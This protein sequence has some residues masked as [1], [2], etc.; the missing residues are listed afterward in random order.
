M[1]RLFTLLFSIVA[2]PFLTTAQN[3]GVDVATPIQKLDVA[4]AIKLGSTTTG[5]AGS[6]RWTGTNFEVHDG[7]QWITFGTGT[8][9]DWAIL[10]SNMYSEPLGNVGIGT[11]TPATKLQVVG[12]ARVTALNVGGNYT[13]PTLDGG[14][15]FVLSTNGT[16]TVTWAD[17]GLTGDITSVVAGDGLI[18]GGTSGD[19]TVDVNPG[20]GIIL[21]G[22]AVVVQAS[23][24]EGNGLVANSNNFD[25]NVDNSTIEVNADQ[26]RV[27]AEGITANEIATGGVTTSEIL[28]G[29]IVTGDIATGGVNSTNIL[30]ATIVAADMAV[31]GNDQV[32]TTDGSGNPQWVNQNVMFL[33]QAGDGIILDAPNSELDINVDNST[34]EVNA[35][36]LRVKTSGITTSQI[37]DG[38][39]VTADIAT[40]GVTST[41]ILDGTIVP[42]DI[43]TGGVNSTNILDGTIAAED[44]G[45]GGAGQILATDATGTSV[46]WVNP[47]SAIPGLSD[48]DDDTRV[49]V[50]ANPDED[51]IRFDTQGSERMIIDETGNIGIGTTA[52]TYKLDIEGDLGINGRIYHNDDPNTSIQYT[53]DRLRVY[54]GNLSASWIDIQNAALEM[55][56]N[57]DGIQRD[58]RVESGSDAN[59]LIVVG[60][61][62]NVGVGTAAPATKFEV[63]GTARV[64]ELN[65]G[66]NYSLPT[67]DG[68]NT[69][70]MQTDGAGSVVWVDPTS[71]LT[72]VPTI[73]SD[74][75]LDT[76]IEVEQSADEDHIRMSTVGVERLTIDDAGQVGI[77]TNTPD[78]DLHIA[79]DN[80]GTLVLTR[81]DGSPV[82]SGSTLGELMFDSEAD[83]GPSPNDASAVIRGIASVTQGDSDKGG[84]MAFLTKTS[85]TDNTAAASERMRITSTG[86]VGI[87]TATPTEAVEV[88]GASP[89]ILISNTAE[90]NAGLMFHDSQASPTSQLAGMQFNSGS[91]NDLSFYNNSSGARMVI[92]NSGEVGIGTSNP[93]HP[94]EVAGNELVTGRSYIGT[95]DAY[96]YRDA[97]NRIAT[98]DMFYVQAS[99]PN[100]YLYSTNT[101]LGNSSGDNIYLRANRFNW[102]SGSGGEITTGGNLGLG[103]T[104]PEFKV[105]INHDGN[106]KAGNN[107][108]VSNLA[109]KIGHTTETGGYASG[110]GFGRSGV[111]S[112]VGGAI[113]FE[114]IGSQSNGHLHFATKNTSVSGGDIPIRMTLS[115][116]GRLGVGTTAPDHT[117]DV[118][119]NAEIS[120]LAG[121]G[122]RVVQAD[123][124]GT[125]I[126]SNN[127]PANDGS[128]IWNS[129]AGQG[130]NFRISGVGYVSTLY[131]YNSST[132]YWN[133]ASSASMRVEGN[134]YIGYGSNSDDDLIYFDRNGEYLMWYNS[135]NYFRVSDDFAADYSIRVGNVSGSDDDYLYFDATAEYIRWD[136]SPG[137]FDVSDDF[138]MQG[139]DLYYVDQAFIDDLYAYGTDTYIEVWDEF[140]MN[141]NSILDA[142]DVQVNTL[143]DPEDSWVYVPDNMYWNS[144]NAS[145]DV[146]MGY[147]GSYPAI[148][149]P[150]N[151]QGYLGTYY[152]RWRYSYTYYEYRQYEYNYSDRR[153]KENIR[154]LTNTGSLNKIMQLEGM[155]YDMIP[156]KLQNLGRMDASEL[157]EGANTEPA[158]LD[159]GPMK[160]NLG[161][162][163]QDLMLVIPEMVEYDEE[164]DVYMIKNYEQMFPV[165]V[166]AMK[167]QQAQIESQ[168]QKIANLEV[169]IQQLLQ[170]KK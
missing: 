31:A 147:Y 123:A 74:A 84:H 101:F 89:S 66:G 140:D 58:F 49:L 39:I 139:N 62:D 99:S 33:D 158:K 144:P 34:V 118:V 92:E 14:A 72:A 29:T 137:E 128:Y 153:M 106:A 85:S 67:A 61:S 83:S 25:V 121:S 103:M 24:L 104:A 111:Q 53:P 131:D 35:D 10:G 65:V 155:K 107:V 98:P 51:K 120:A 138:N 43:A 126:V 7:T 156:E 94:L 125:L 5:A 151:Y 152:N 90:T 105:Q 133:G 97:A 95:T 1:K 80:G 36:V 73:L 127:L 54:A 110:L 50:E 76:K 28:N 148:Y 157:P 37:L 2:L 60:S 15:G 69:Y 82:T 6:M 38:T 122:N 71:V 132:Y 32:L 27:K 86:D 168:D 91:D 48:G 130:A 143:Y 63:A 149:T 100:T 166:E 3:V 134:I 44:V 30:D 41:N 18:N 46:S 42:I 161:F 135:G 117:L 87:G 141:D 167:E 64:T 93:A 12:T 96:F 154:P 169:L 22:D 19:V 159:E 164:H 56:I 20:D 11:T 75:D 79:N 109:M 113:I 119:G 115:D 124:S 142:N 16:G 55:A 40:G 47:T 170:E 57:E 77:G 145:Y 136:N 21:L 165:V 45:A 8:D 116:A 108:D 4:G 23:Q 162:I 70:L 52:P 68:S 163:A 13:L 112:N 26:V 78:R 17:P 88:E 129:T 59:A 150:G 102:T 114:R 9:N 160:D 146:N 81:N